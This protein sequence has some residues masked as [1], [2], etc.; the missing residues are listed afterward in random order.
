MV[1]PGG[2]QLGTYWEGMVR[3]FTNIDGNADGT[4]Q[5]AGVCAEVDHNTRHQ[6]ASS[7]S[8]VS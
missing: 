3:R 6:I 8:V 7:L 4:K 2:V 5:H 1:A